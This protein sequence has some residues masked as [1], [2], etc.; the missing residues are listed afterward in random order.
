MHFAQKIMRGYGTNPAA[1]VFAELFS[2]SDKI[3]A[4]DGKIKPVYYRFTAVAEA[5]SFCIDLHVVSSF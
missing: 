2:K 3:T 4:K 1:K 5:K